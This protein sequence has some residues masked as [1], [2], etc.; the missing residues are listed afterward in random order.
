MKTES[1]VR[2]TIELPPNV[3]M[4]LTQAATQSNISVDQLAA[5]CISQSIETA[6]RHRVLLDRQEHIDEALLTIAEFLGALSA[7]PFDIASPSLGS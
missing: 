7:A 6:L 3:F 2:L 5:D 4:A 1:T